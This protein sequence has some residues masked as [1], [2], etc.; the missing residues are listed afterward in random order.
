MKAHWLYLQHA[1]GKEN[2]IRIESSELNLISHVPLSDSCLSWYLQCTNSDITGQINLIYDTTQFSSHNGKE[3][4]MLCNLTSETRTQ[5]CT[6][7]KIWVWLWQ[8]PLRWCLT[9]HISKTK[10]ST[11]WE[12]PS[13]FFLTVGSGVPDPNCLVSRDWNNSPLCRCIISRIAAASHVPIS[14]TRWNPLKKRAEDGVNQHKLLYRSSK[15]GGLW[16]K[17]SLAKEVS[18]LTGYLLASMW[19]PHALPDRAVKSGI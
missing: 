2:I 11:Y 6:G 5:G 19:Y 12:H 1:E 8:Q 15:Q 3:V 9:A 10:I 16:P 18:L 4:P 13:G 7:L 14:C 17:C